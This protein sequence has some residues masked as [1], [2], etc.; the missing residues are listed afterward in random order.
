VAQCYFLCEAERELKEEHGLSRT[1]RN[2][3]SE[4]RRAVITSQAASALLGCM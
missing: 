2:L 3:G 1:E 4:E